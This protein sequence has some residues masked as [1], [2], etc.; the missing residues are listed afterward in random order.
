M[1]PRLPLL[2]LM[3]LSALCYHAAL[4]LEHPGSVWP[5]AG[6]AVGLCAMVRARTARRASSPGV[7]AALRGAGPQLWVP[8]GSRRCF[9]KRLEEGWTHH[10]DRSCRARWRT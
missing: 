1:V 7:G 6:W 9:G 8:I 3:V 5:T 2:L 10:R 4:W